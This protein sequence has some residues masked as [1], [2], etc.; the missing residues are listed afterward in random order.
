MARSPAA[1]VLP[2]PKADAALLRAFVAVARLGGVG[3]AAAA[4]ALTQP[5]VSA[6]VATLEGLWDVLLFR[7]QSRG[8]TLTPEGAR[9]LPLAEAALRA[10]EALDAAAGLPVAAAGEIRV[11]SGD[12]LGR[13]LLPRTLAPL[14]AN[15]PALGVRLVEGPGARLLGAV[16]DGEID[17]ALLVLPGDETVL[18]GLD[19]TPL[20][21][22][23]VDVLFPAGRA[24]R[25]RAALPIDALR[26]RRLVAL[27]EGSAFRR[28]VASAFDTAGVPFQ[29]AVEVG[30]LSLVRRFVA[31]GAGA[32]P[33]PAIAF[34]GKRS[35]IGVER[36]R[37]AG[38]PSVRYVMAVRA[39]GRLPAG[40]QDFIAALSGEAAR[41][42]ST[43]APITRR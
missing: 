3:R 8:M 27:Q 19:V 23:P 24:P 39:G 35:E 7:R 1:E 14:L 13:E 12:A 11:G 30:N 43:A 32:A 37:L 29:P 5:S 41:L 16:R 28:H 31:A 34:E 22:S 15:D 26:H 9:L 42:S 20:L 33:V 4:L 36:R 17:I 25:G 2:A 21:E 10:L 40:A 6:R 38:I 18:R